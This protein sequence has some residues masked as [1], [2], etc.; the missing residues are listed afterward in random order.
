[1]RVPGGGA[2]CLGVGRPGSGALSPPTARP[3]GRAAGAHYPLAVRAGDAGVGTCH[4]PHGARSCE[5]ALRAVGVARGRLGGAPPAWAWG[6]RSRAL[7]HHRPLVLWGVRPGPT[8]HWLWVRGIRAWGPVINPTACASESTLCALLGRHEGAWGGGALPGC[9]AS[10]VGRSPTPKC[11]S[12]GACGQGPL[13]TGCGCSMRACGPGCPWHLLTCRGSLY[14]VRASRVCGTQWPLS[15]GT[16]PRAVVVACSVPLWRA[17]SPR[18]G[19]PRLV[20]SG[21]SRCSSRLSRRRGAFPHHGWC[22]P[23]LYWVDAWGKWRPA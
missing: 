7:S 14:V 17:S 12:F 16:F 3:L 20:P 15:L 1:M 2:S 13:L 10:G 6:V 22:R 18:I 9:G 11:S 21:H 5:P 19:A 4:Q 23:R 8:T